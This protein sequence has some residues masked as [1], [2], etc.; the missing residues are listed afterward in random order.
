MSKLTQTVEWRSRYLQSRREGLL[1]RGL[2]LQC[3]ESPVVAGRK[4]C[5]Q[6]LDRDNIKVKA[7]RKTPKGK[8]T[9][10]KYRENSGRF[11]AISYLAVQ[12]GKPWAL[13]EAE[14]RVLISQP[15]F[16]CG[17]ENN[18]KTGAGL[19]RLNNMFGYIPGNVVSCCYECNTARADNFTPEEMKIIG[20]AIHQVKFARLGWVRRDW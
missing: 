16:Y 12:Q 3:G 20:H 17:M 9:I 1:A 8:A 19:D 18:V 10:K 5:R 6:C 15:C 4:R 13:S 2:C 14:W 7:Y 11:S